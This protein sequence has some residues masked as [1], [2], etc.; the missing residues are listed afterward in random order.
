MAISLNSLIRSDTPRPPIITEHGG[1]GIGKTTLAA[2]FPSPVFIQTEDGLDSVTVD[3]FPL[4]KSFSDVMEAL[5]AL[6]TEDHQFKTVVIDSLDWL[7]PLVWAETCRRHQ[8][9]SIETPGYGKGYIEAQSVWREYL[10]GVTALRDDKGMCVVQIAHSEI[11]R[12][13][14]P[15]TE[16]Y[17]RFEIKL[18]KRSAALIAEY[19]DVILFMNRQVSTTQSDVGFNKKVARAISTGQVLIY[20]Q[21][22]PA[23]IAKNRH[24][25]PDAIPFSKGQGY[26]ALAPYFPALPQPASTQAA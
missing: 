14:N 21:E 5:G 9:P 18:Q 1:P 20:S 7:E 6:Y 24:G 26:A 17:D 22:R 8:W 15:E 10:D 25:M 2:E 23:F 19:S 16:P 3:A 12:F 13:E 4:A 11:K